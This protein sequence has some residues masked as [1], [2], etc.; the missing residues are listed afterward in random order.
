MPEQQSDDNDKPSIKLKEEQDCY[1]KDE[2]DF[3]SYI[4][5]EVR[6]D[7]KDEARKVGEIISAHWNDDD[8]QVEADLV[9]LLS[10]CWDLMNDMR[11]LESSRGGLTDAQRFQRYKRLRSEFEA[12]LASLED[13]DLPEDHNSKN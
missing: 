10:E 8:Y 3:G 4:P 5:V 1:N 9:G 7:S 6:V 13:T 2:G 11:E 12:K